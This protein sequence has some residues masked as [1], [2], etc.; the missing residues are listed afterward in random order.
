VRPRRETHAIRH[1]ALAAVAAGLL[2]L[3]ARADCSA[4][5]VQERYVF[6][7]SLGKGSYGTVYL[8]RLKVDR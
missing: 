2:S 5:T 8:A 6:V 3:R 4:V 7:R 1:G